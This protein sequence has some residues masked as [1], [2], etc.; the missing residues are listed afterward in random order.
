MTTICTSNSTAG[1][2]DLASFD[3]LE[4]YLYGGEK[5]TSYFVRDIK[6]SS[7]FT[8]IPVPLQSSG[9]CIDFGTTFSVSITRSADYLLNTWLHLQM[10]ELN[11][12]G[13]DYL[14]KPTQNFMHNLVQDCCLTCNELVVERFDSRFLDFWAG[15]TVPR[16]KSNTYNNMINY[17]GLTPVAG[18]AT[19]NAVVLNLPLPFFF[20]RD[21]GLALPTAALPYNEMLIT[22]TLRPLEELFTVINTE[23]TPHVCVPFVRGS[24]A[25]QVSSSTSFEL[26]N[27]VVWGNYA[28]VSNDERKKMACGSRDILIEQVQTTGGACFKPKS[29]N[30]KKLFHLKFT[31]SIKVLF[32]ALMNTTCPG[33]LSNY[34]TGSVIDQLASA[35]GSGV[36]PIASTSVIYE[37][38]YRLANMTSDYYSLVQ[39]W[40]HAPAGPADQVSPGFTSNNAGNNPGT[41]YHMYSYALDFFCIDPMG[42]TNYGKLTNITI[43]ILPS[44]GLI[45]TLNYDLPNV[46][47]FYCVAVNYNMIRISGG[48]LG[49]PVL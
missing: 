39:P 26:R 43:G 27:T 31:H 7:W 25:G 1:Y 13:A 35:A 22:I 41:G 18:Q 33:D 32:F 6:K 20:S 46:Y 48:A 37:N 36:D 21:S 10:P 29:V 16:S 19:I 24:A 49:F 34:Q 47:E 23:P 14:L 45:T 12:N 8:Q 44:N 38:T 15:F 3:E 2:I 5:C 40:Y 4:K 28:I 17:Q 9:G 11:V 30:D 42:S